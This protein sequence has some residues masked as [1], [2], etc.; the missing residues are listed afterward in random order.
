LI[1]IL[2]L[3]NFGRGRDA[4]ASHA[5]TILI[6]RIGS[7]HVVLELVLVPVHGLALGLDGA[8]RTMVK[9]QPTRVP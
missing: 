5:R 1:F 3:P 8:T 6:S 2:L 7:G 4:V 9:M